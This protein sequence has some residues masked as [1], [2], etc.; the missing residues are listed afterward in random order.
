[1][2]TLLI[3]TILLLFTK[4]KVVLFK[5]KKMKLYKIDIGVPT[6]AVMMAC[7]FL[8]VPVDMIDVNLPGNEHLTSK[9]LKVNFKALLCP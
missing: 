5:K 7:E 4:Y 1:M 8:R 2:F 9:F 3:K 6:R